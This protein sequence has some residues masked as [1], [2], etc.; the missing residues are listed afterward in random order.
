MFTGRFAVLDEPGRPGAPAAV[1]VPD[2]ADPAAC[3]V[4]RF[5]AVPAPP[6][7]F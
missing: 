2:C 6:G 4:P 3:V 5:T 1:P 7:A